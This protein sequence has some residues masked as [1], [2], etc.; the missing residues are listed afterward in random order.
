M[1]VCHNPF[2]NR[3]D[4]PTCVVL[5]GGLGTRMQPYTF[6]LQKVMVGYQGKPILHYVV[7]YWSKYSDDFI[8]ITGYK[9]EQVLAYIP[10]FNIRNYITIDGNPKKNGLADA[11]A[12]TESNV[13]DNFIIALGDCFVSGILE[14]PKIMDQGVG[15]VRDR[16]EIHRN[17]QVTYDGY[18]IT[19][20]EEK[21]E[22]VT[23]DLCGMGCYFFNKKL[24]EY[25]PYTYPSA[26]T[27]R[28]ELTDV[29]QTMINDNNVVK[30]VFLKG[31]YR[32]ITCPSDVKK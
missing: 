2:I 7:D 19:K 28:V 8:F 20:V 9:Q 4:K 6:D 16:S 30:P 22:I 18:K 5:C 14:F 24:F 15:V 10:N 3:D 21:P 12:L 1:N 17:Y 11:I 27:H 23:G 32:N 26:R 25:I 13:K 29:I 31:I